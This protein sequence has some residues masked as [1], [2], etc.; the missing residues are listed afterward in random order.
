RESSRKTYS[1]KL[2]QPPGRDAA[3]GFLLPRTQRGCAAISAGVPREERDQPA[4]VGNA[5]RRR[6]TVFGL[7]F[8]MNGPNL[9]CEAQKRGRLAGPRRAF[10]YMG[11]RYSAMVRTTLE[12]GRASP[13]PGPFTSLRICSSYEAIVVTGNFGFMK[14]TL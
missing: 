11:E 5:R 7:L 2:R 12:V 4:A 8:T 9:R 10:G 13:P 6:S 14:T 3:P 1:P